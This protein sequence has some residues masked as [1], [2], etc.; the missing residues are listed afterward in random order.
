MQVGCVGA[1]AFSISVILKNKHFLLLYLCWTVMLSAENCF[2]ELLSLEL[3]TLRCSITIHWEKKTK[4][5]AKCTDIIKINH[6]QQP[7]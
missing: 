6:G 2:E 3:W 7:A 1:L 4:K 5:D